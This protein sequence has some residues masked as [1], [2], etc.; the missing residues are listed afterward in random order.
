MR[1]P[2]ALRINAVTSGQ[3]MKHADR[4]IRAESK[5][6]RLFIWSGHQM[7]EYRVPRSYRCTR[8]I[9]Y[10]ATGASSVKSSMSPSEHALAFSLAPIRNYS[11]R[12]SRWS[13]PPLWGSHTALPTHK[14][15]VGG[16]T[17]A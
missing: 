3:I 7:S 17:N 6:A 8:T 13:C 12:P 5:L 14:L 4:C 10:T 2:R 1:L 9:A 11:M 16:V 15:K